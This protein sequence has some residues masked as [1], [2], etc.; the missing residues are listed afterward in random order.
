MS[1][2]RPPEPPEPP[3]PPAPELF[4][5]LPAMA[6]GGS[7][8]LPRP[9]APLGCE[10]GKE[11]GREGGASPGRR[12]RRRRRLSGQRRAGSLLLRCGWLPQGGLRAGR[13]AAPPRLCPDEP[14]AGGNQIQT[15]PG[16]GGPRGRP[17]S[18]RGSAGRCRVPA[19]SAAAVSSAPSALRMLR[20]S[21][22]RSGRAAHAAAG[23][24]S[25]R[26]KHHW[27]LQQR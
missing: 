4:F 17:A 16:C 11:G 14:A 6:R 2:M 1:P 25:R 3:P 21:R 24:R 22:A 23:P 20:G 5:T 9:P 18:P 12:R 10:R 13:F 26:R 19:G 7:G 15:G 27:A 8:A